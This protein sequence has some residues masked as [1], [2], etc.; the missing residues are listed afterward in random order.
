MLITDLEMI[1]KKAY[2]LKLTLLYAMHI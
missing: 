2:V 1:V